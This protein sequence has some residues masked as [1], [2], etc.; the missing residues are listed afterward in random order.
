MNN[1][2]PILY[3][4]EDESQ[5]DEK[6][7]KMIEYRPHGLCQFTEQ[8]QEYIHFDNLKQSYG[9]SSLRYITVGYEN[10]INCSGEFGALR[11]RV[12]APFC[13][14]QININIKLTFSVFIHT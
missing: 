12:T 4:H 5:N 10:N 13:N 14:S 2:Y 6:S 8:I 1:T 11:G 9:S 3:N 7:K